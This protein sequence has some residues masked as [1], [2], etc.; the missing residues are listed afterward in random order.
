MGERRTNRERGQGQSGREECADPNCACGQRERVLGRLQL[1]P[2]LPGVP[3][4]LKLRFGL[5]QGAARSAR[6]RT[7]DGQRPE[8]AQTVGAAARLVDAAEFPVA[9]ADGVVR[10]VLVHTGAEAGWAELKSHRT[11]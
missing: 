11:E 5:F 3:A 10:P 6:H 8:P 7:I 4:L 2:R 1:R 9:G